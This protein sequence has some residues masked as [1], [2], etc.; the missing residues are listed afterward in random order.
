MQGRKRTLG[1]KFMDYA[2]TLG[3]ENL[4]ALQDKCGIRLV[5]GLCSKEN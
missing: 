4:T 3:I 1:D 2:R 5:R